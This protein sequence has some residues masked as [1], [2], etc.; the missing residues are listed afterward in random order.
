MTEKIIIKDIKEEIWKIREFNDELEVIKDKIIKFYEI[1][2]NLGDSTKKLWISDI[3]E[4]YYSI[5]S[6]WELI[7]GYNG[8]KDYLESSKQYFY[9][10][11][12]FC[13][14]SKSELN[15]FKTEEATDLLSHLNIT[16][17]KCFKAYREILN[18]LIPQKVT[19]KPIKKVIKVSNTE[20]Q[21]L[22]SICGELAVCF[23]IGKALFNN[24]K[25]LIYAG[26]THKSSLKKELSTELFNLLEQE[27]FSTIH[28]FIKKYHVY[29]GLDAYCPECNDIYC[30][31]HY[32]PVEEFDDGFYDCTY[33]TCPKGHR[34]I[35]DD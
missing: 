25:S 27:N 8:E 20:Y 34:R 32:N 35:I 15:T 14:Q 31:E 11:Q 21:I 26:I 1:Q 2:Q 29:E 10:T 9:R 19:I 33:G 22:C 23:K 6:V 17:D 5:I 12:S 16:F 3:K 18:I 30:W 13:S 28:A 7:W 4:C 24:E